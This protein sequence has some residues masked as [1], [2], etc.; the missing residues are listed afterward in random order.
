MAMFDFRKTAAAP[1]PPEPPA[2]ATVPAGPSSTGG[3]TPLE[4]L[5]RGA[6]DEGGSDLHI[7]VGAPPA[8]R[9]HGHRLK[10]NLPIPTPEN[11]ETLARAVTSDAN[12]QRVNTEGSVDFVL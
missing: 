12:L 11:T 2:R 7:S 6:V 9:L 5:L 1:P 3:L 4:D 10:L 8:I